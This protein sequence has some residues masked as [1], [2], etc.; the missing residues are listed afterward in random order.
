MRGLIYPVVFLI[1]AIMIAVSFL[2]LRPQSLWAPAVATFSAIAGKVHGR[3]ESH[4]SPF[5]KPKAVEKSRAARQLPPS[6]A[7]EGSVTVTVI[8]LPPIAPRRFPLAQEIS[9]GMAKS[10]VLASFGAPTA[11]VTGADVGELLERLLYLDESTMRTTLIYF[12]DG[13]VI[14]SETYTRPLEG[15]RS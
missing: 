3:A 15:P 13:R 6:I 11:T 5:S 9:K 10:A 14:R 7:S 8:P 2:I 12:V 1:A 4:P